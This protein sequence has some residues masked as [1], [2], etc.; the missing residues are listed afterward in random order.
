M[1][2]DG[3]GG[4]DPGVTAYVNF[5]MVSGDGA[6]IAGRNASDVFAGIRRSRTAEDGAGRDDCDIIPY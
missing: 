2:Y 1:A 6:R 5:V 3:V 4:G